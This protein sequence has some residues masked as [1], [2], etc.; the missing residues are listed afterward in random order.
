MDVD[1]STLFVQFI[2]GLSRAMILFLMASG[3]TL[4]FGVMRVINFAHGAFYMLGAYLAFTMTQALTGAIG[5]WAALILVPTVV[6][7]VGG[8]VEIILLRRIYD[9]EHLLQILL[10]YALIFVFNDAVRMI[11]GVDLRIV[12]LPKSLAGFATFFGHRFPVYYFFII[13]VGVAVA[14]FLWLFL[15]KTRFGKLLR[16]SAEQGD[17]V[18][19]LGYNVRGLFT[20][21]FMMATW[22]GGL[23][24]AV[25]APTIR[26][27]LG[28]DMEII[29]EC[30]IVVIVGGLGN[31][32][33]ALLG[34]LITGQIYA[35]GILFVPKYA[36]AFLFALAAVIIMFRPY[37]L[38]GKAE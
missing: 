24:G 13:A 17:M 14:F 5:F 28:M 22:L 31:I 20:L 25:I 38:L 2:S 6:C 18:N 12:D 8:L 3:L 4:V 36:M 19:L 32:W 16:A 11:W 1:P 15:K 27:S 29:I 26:L 23:S 21:V 9:K 7:I 34:A 30:F 10:T 35:F 33:G 37:G